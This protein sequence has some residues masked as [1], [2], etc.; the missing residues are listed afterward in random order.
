MYTGISI[1]IG[2]H[3]GDYIGGSAHTRYQD[4]GI[5]I[6]SGKSR[7][8]VEIRRDIA[9]LLEVEWRRSADEF[10]AVHRLAAEAHDDE[11]Q[12]DQLLRIALQHFGPQH[13]R[14]LVDACIEHGKQEG[15]AEHQKVMRDATELSRNIFQ[16]EYGGGDHG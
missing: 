4:E 1:V 12:R 16:R 6:A 13:L 9:D 8:V 7:V 2:D 3:V 11:Q 14:E 5:R 10:S 15:W